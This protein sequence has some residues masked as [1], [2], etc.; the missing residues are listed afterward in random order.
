MGNLIIV[1]GMPASGKSCFAGY[2]SRKLHI[3]LVS[4]DSIKE[5]LF[6]YIG[7]K[8]HEEKTALNNASLFAMLYMARQVLNED[9]DIILENNFENNAIVPIN[10]IISEVRC[11]V[12]SILFSGEMKTLY[13]RYIDRSYSPERH[14]GHALSECYPVT[15]EQSGKI[16]EPITF[17]Q[18][19]T[20]FTARGMN[21]FVIG[22]NSI[23]VDATD[24]DKVS[25][26]QIIGEI[27]NY[28]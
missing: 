10:K 28:L 15:G 4:K 13:K 14:R 1:S 20:D 7:F 16:P 17:D 6:D 18:Y 21:S 19:S 11:N 25:Y 5:I 22:K 27:R 12:V 2:A 8:S 23:I 3:P 24:F 26:D 9:G